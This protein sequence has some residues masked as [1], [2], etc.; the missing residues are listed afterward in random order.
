[1]KWVNNENWNSRISNEIT[2][3]LMKWN[4]ACI[5]KVWSQKIPSIARPGALVKAMDLQVATAT[6]L[7]SVLHALGEGELYIMHIAFSLLRGHN[8][9]LSAHRPK[10]TV[11][12][13]S[14]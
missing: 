7:V 8:W 12:L 4:K 10:C 2:E 1:M 13:N 6:I 3:Q 14:N 11:T 9:M 5:I